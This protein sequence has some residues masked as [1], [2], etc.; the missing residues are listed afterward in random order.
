MCYGYFIFMAISP[1]IRSPS[2]PDNAGGSVFMYRITLP[3]LLIKI[4]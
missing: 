4:V 2:Q 3:D 1:V